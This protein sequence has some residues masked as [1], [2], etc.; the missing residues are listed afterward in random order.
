[1]TIGPSLPPIVGSDKKPFYVSER[2]FIGAEH[3]N[4]W[5][6]WTRSHFDRATVEH[7][8]EGFHSQPFHCRG[9]VRV[10]L[11]NSN[12]GAYRWIDTRSIYHGKT[13]EQDANAII[14]TVTSSGQGYLDFWEDLPVNLVV[15]AVLPGLRQYGIALDYVRVSDRRLQLTA[16]TSSTGPPLISRFEILIYGS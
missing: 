13:V 2:G 4:A 11:N 6:E 15:I 14:L 5:T 7:D 16:R 9:V 3:V 8:P 12:N 1:M 10:N